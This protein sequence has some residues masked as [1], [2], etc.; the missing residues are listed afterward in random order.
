MN[1]ADWAQNTIMSM[2]RFGSTVLTKLWSIAWLDCGVSSVQLCR[3]HCRIWLRFSS[4][5]NFGLERMDHFPSEYE[6]DCCAV[7]CFDFPDTHRYSDETAYVHKHPAAPLVECRRRSRD[8]ANLGKGIAHLLQGSV[9]RYFEVDTT[10][11]ETLA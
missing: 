9:S 1:D 7:T 11:N 8:R 2:L 3:Q 5:R 4:L 10:K 6:C